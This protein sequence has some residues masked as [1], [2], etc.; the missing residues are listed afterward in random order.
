MKEQV[1]TWNPFLVGPLVI[2]LV[3]KNHG[4][5]SGKKG[6]IEFP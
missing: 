2:I 1:E 3:S 5:Q 6:A 4:N